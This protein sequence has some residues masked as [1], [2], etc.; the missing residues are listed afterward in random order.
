M[1]SSNFDPTAANANDWTNADFNADGNVDI[2]DFNFL[3]SNFAPSGYG[4]GPGQIPE[5]NTMLLL[6]LGLLAVAGWRHTRP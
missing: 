4:D 6:G 3:S 5:P 2:T 1:L